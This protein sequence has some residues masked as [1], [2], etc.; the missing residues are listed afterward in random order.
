[1]TRLRGP[2]SVA[3]PV[4]FTSKGDTTRDAFRKH[5]DEITRIYGILTGLDADTMD[6]D[7]V[8]DSVN[9]ILQNW[10]P[11]MSFSDISGNLDASKVSGKLTNANIDTGKVNG[12]EAF[13]KGLIPVG[14]TDSSLNSNGYVNFYD[15]F[16]LQW[17]TNDILTDSSGHYVNFP[18]Q[19][20]SKCLHVLV[21]PRVYWNEV[22]L[23][24]K[25][26][27]AFTVESLSK[28]GFR[29]KFHCFHHPDRPLSEIQTET[30]INYMAIGV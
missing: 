1:M 2:Y 5:M 25:T 23:A 11:S 8:N 7:N 3:F 15:K 19:F 18:K 24:E 27:V 28:T 13:V 17:G 29:Y 4:N 9:K 21:T 10:K 16:M 22:L 20:S 30:R 12:L 26:V 14:I 6:A